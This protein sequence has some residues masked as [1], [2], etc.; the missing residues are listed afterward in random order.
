MVTPEQT[1]IT[2]KTKLTELTVGDLKAL[3]RE[4]VEDVVHDAV[5][6]LEQQLPDPDEGKELKP[7]FAERLRESLNYQGK[8]Y[9]LEEV[10]R[11]LG[12]DE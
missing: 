2:D 6:H 10:K 12:L 9:S 3:I 1:Q 8:T 11:E 4:I 7:E 5:F